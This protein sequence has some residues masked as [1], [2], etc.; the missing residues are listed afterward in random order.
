MYV[1]YNYDTAADSITFDTVGRWTLACGEDSVH[2][3]N[4][5]TYRKQTGKKIIQLAVNCIE[6]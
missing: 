3:T 6:D 4:Q 5:L 1:C 2:C